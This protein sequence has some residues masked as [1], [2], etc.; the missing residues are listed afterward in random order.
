MARL[1]CQSCL[2]AAAREL[3]DQGVPASEVMHAILGLPASRD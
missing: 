2:E 3:L 1:C